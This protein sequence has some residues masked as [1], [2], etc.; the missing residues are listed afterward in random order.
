MPYVVQ[1][2]FIVTFDAGC[3]FSKSGT[4]YESVR[5][6]LGRFMNKPTRA[7]LNLLPLSA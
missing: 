2:P 1:I 7:F 4:I 5:D 3:R 6:E